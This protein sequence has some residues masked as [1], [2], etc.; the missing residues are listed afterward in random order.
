[1][2]SVAETRRLTTF[3][4]STLIEVLR[5]HP[6]VLSFTRSCPFCSETCSDSSLALSLSNPCGSF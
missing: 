2:K 6:K 1:M 5:M 4:L 3:E